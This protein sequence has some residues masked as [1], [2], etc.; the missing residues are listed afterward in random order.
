[1]MDVLISK[2]FL[3]K[4]NYSLKITTINTKFGPLFDSKK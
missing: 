1:M 3:L 4:T 2:F